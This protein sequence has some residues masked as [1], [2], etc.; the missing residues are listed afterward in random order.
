MTPG[1]C[2]VVSRRATGRLDPER[3]ARATRAARAA[4]DLPRDSG[5][6]ASNALGGATTSGRPWYT[7]ESRG[8]P[9]PPALRMP[10]GPDAF[11][12]ARLVQRAPL[13]PHVAGVG[14]AA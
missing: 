4:G 11:G 12:R 6:R 7:P 9:P 8:R 14:E 3:S 13:A 2:W 10:G 1:S 5:A